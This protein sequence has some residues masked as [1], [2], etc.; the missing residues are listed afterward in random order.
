MNQ[1]SFMRHGAKPAGSNSRLIGADLLMHRASEFRFMVISFNFTVP[2]S[3]IDE[4]SPVACT[5]AHH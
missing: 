1:L 5:R 4:Q 2:D 3:V